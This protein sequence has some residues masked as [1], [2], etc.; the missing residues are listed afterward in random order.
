MIL[1]KSCRIGGSGRLLFSSS[2]F[3]TGIKT[4]LTNDVCSRQTVALSR[5]DLHRFLWRELIKSM[6][7]LP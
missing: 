2:Y 7:F 5:H 1:L 4:V 6:F 3:C